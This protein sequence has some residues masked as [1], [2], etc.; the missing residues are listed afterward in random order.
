MGFIFRGKEYAFFDVTNEKHVK[1]DSED[2]LELTR[3]YC[4]SEG[5]SVVP[6][7]W[8]AIGLVAV[9]GLGATLGIGV[10][11]YLAMRTQGDSRVEKNMSQFTGTKY[12]GTF[13]P[14]PCTSCHDEDPY[15]FQLQGLVQDH[16]ELRNPLPRF[17]PPVRLTPKFRHGDIL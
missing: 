1:A 8:V 10:G 11:Y 3:S 12:D 4:K 13:D 16:L 2:A 9:L 15:R 17:V 14:H 7:R 6:R 5:F